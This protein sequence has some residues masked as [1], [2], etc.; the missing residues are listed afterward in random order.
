MVNQ[1]DIHETVLKQYAEGPALLE[2]ALAGLTESDLD[3][4]LSTDSWSIRQLV[5]HIADG[6]D[7]W[8]TCIK[9]ALGNS[10]GLFSLQ[11]Y[12]EK[13]QMEWS[14]NWTYTS[15]G[16]AS[17]LALLRANRRH[18]LEL[19]EHTPNALEKSIRLYRPGT[20]EDR[21][22]VLDVLEMY[23]RHMADHIKDIQAT[24]QA[25]GAGDVTKTK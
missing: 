25:H 19:L 5:H 13:P 12:W 10:E 14:E 6:D 7:L 17:S 23:V 2:S 8:K 20:S 21:V 9:A 15:R 24:L 18:I 11:W 16:I 1:T 4:A 3:L 22:T